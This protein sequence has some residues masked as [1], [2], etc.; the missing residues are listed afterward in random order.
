[1]KVSF[2][3]LE[4]TLVFP[5]QLHP[6]LPGGKISTKSIVTIGLEDG[7]EISF[8]GLDD[9]SAK[10]LYVNFHS[11]AESVDIS[12]VDVEKGEP[13]CKSNSQ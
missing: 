2:V 10:Y 13:L 12:V 8:S 1:M 3:R 9:D 11:I 7:K 4:G 6:A 5:I